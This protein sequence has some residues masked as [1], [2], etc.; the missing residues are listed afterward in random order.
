M[1]CSNPDCNTNANNFP[2]HISDSNTR[3]ANM[4]WVGYANLSI[5]NLTPQAGQILRVTSADVNLS[6]EIELPDVIDGRIDKTVYK[7]GPKIVEGTL[8]M[9]VIADVDETQI[10]TGCPANVKT[11]A[12]EL[13]NDLW[14]WSLSRGEQ[15]RLQY[16]DATLDI[17][18]ANHAAFRFDHCLVNTFGLGVTQGDQ[19]SLDLNVYGRGRSP[20]SNTL[21]AP[22]ITNFLSPARVLTWNDITITGAGGCS[23]SGILWYSNQVREFKLDINNN[24]DRFYTLAGSLFPVDINVGQREIS[25]S[26][27]LMGLNDNLRVLAETNEERFTEKNEI[28]IAIYIGDDTWNPGL[29]GGTFDS[30]DWTGDDA[31]GN[32]IFAKR[33]SSVVFKIEEIAM[34]NEVL[35]TTVNWLALANDQ[36]N[37]EAIE[38]C[39]SSTFPVWE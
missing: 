3:F 17:R 29:G 12:G 31:I 9:P 20:F 37:Y 7:L 25:G 32:P 16:P 34:T 36:N 4:G 26:I 13:L 6:Q 24:A 8:S 27:T 5:K 21:S 15:G 11:V 38:P 28:R 33:L 39:A 18:Y 1:P 30:R 22:T 19:I 14:C 23:N 2:S 35:E 10:G